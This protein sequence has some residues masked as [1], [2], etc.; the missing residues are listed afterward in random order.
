MENLTGY[1]FTQGALGVG[2]LVLG[3]VC[4]KLYSRSE[5]K[6]E[7]LQLRIEE[8]HSLRLEDSNSS[9][10]VVLDVLRDNTQN[11]RVFSEKIEVV[12]SRSKEK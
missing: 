11:M 10:E 3:W 12:Q 6:I 4:V 7:A 8:L 9:R 5:A 2:C 1:L